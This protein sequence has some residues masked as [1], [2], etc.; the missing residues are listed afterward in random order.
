MSHAIKCRYDSGVKRY[1]SPHKIRAADHHLRSLDSFSKHHGALLKCSTIV[2][3][4]AGV[5]KVCSIRLPHLRQKR[6]CIGYDA[7][8]SLHMGAVK[9]P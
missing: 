6:S 3:L 4:N 5:L 7:L 8:L 9:P 2:D 1:L